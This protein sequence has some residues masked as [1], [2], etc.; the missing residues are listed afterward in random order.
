MI[1]TA[2]QHSF[3]TDAKEEKKIMKWLTRRNVIQRL[4][5]WCWI[6][7]YSVTFWDDIFKLGF[8]S[9]VLRSGFCELFKFVSFFSFLS[10]DPPSSSSES[11]SGLRPSLAEMCSKQKCCFICSY[12]LKQPRLVLLHLSSLSVNS[13]PWGLQRFLHTDE[14]RPNLEFPAWG[15]LLFARYTGVVKHAYSTRVNLYT[16]IKHGM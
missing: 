11:C 16:H 1:I 2:W 12:E 10:F 13:M 14:K 5:F 4:V 15:I 7:N 6:L 9:E 8:L 3:L